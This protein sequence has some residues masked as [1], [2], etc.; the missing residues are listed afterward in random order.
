MKFRLIATASF[1]I[2]S[3]VAQECKNLG[4]E[5]I[6]VENGKVE[7]TT[8]ERGL[9]LAN[10]WLRSADRVYLKL[11]EF[12]AT[13]FTELFD[14]IGNIP[15]EGYLPV[16]AE[17]PIKAKSVKS[18][19]FSKSD[20]QAI[21]KKSIAK[22]LGKFYNKEWLAEDGPRYHILV[23][24]LKDVVT[25]SIDTSG[26]GLHKRGYREQGHHAPLKETMAAALIQISRWQGKIP[27]IDP[28]CGTGTIAIEA[29]LIGRNIAPGLSRNFDF[30]AWSL[31]PD[32]IFKTVKKEAFEKIDHDIELQIEAYDLDYKAIKIARENAELAGVVD[33][34]H[35]QVRDVSELKSP[36]KYGYIITNP[37]YGERLNEIAEVQ[38]LYSV[39]GKQ[40]SELDTWS[41]YVFTSYEEFEK[42][43]MKKATKNRKL[44]N[45]KIKCYFYQYFGPR[46]PRKK[47]L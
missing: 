4:F 43:F 2:E 28:L 17:F 23:G 18:T 38:E 6:K 19:L 36:K 12:K 40:F 14:N 33:D 22:H 44:Y 5:D 39:M 15:W 26:A 10:V 42:F 34:I 29:A 7:F 20:I 27:L 21:S 32:E 30:E 24:I 9:C 31:I 35:F 25:V 3:V 8:D 13:T 1:G 46:P 45:G 41:N 11:A 16:N 47:D 37:P